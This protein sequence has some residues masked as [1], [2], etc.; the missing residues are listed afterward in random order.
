MSRDARHRPVRLR[1]HPFLGLLLS[2]FPPDFRAK[3]G[4]D[5]A[6][7]AESERVHSRY[8]GQQLGPVRFWIETSCDLLTSALRLWVAELAHALAL[9]ARSPVGAVSVSV[10]LSTPG[11]PTMRYELETTANERFKKRATGHVWTGLI[12]A[13]VI[14]FAVLGFFPEFTTADVWAADAEPPITMVPPQVD[15]PEPPAD[16]ARPAEPRIAVDALDTDVTIPAITDSWTTTPELPPPP[17]S[18]GDTD[19]LGAVWLGPSMTRPALKNGAEVQRALRSEY[20]V[21]LRDAGIGGTAVLVL[22]VDA[23]GRVADASVDGTSGYA[24][25]DRAAIAVART[26]EFA[27]AL[28]RDKALAVWVRIPVTFEVQDGR[29]HFSV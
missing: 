26:M 8:A 22:L 9:T 11:G 29:L 28:N 17:T 6:E 25:L 27:P 18:S 5:I 19:D 15:M 13:T 12:A 1:E 23:S 7:A 20:P 3:Y 2:C 4:R 16:I 24:A 10:S 21:I 14:H